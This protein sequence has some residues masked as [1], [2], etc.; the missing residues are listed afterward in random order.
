MSKKLSKKELK[1]KYNIN[2][3]S[4]DKI[5]L[6]QDTLLKWYDL[7]KRDLPWRRTSD[8]Y[9]IWIS[10]IMLQQTRYCYCLL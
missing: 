4:E 3:W 2:M 8:P 9:K 10:E 7:E 1:D 6:F 5:A